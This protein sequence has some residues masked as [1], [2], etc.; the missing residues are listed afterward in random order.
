VT[1]RS[2]I[3]R[4]V[5]FGAA[6]LALSGCSV[7]FHPGS[8]A[9]V[10]GTAIS[11][12]QVND[13][14]DAACS[15]TAE[16]R[17]T[18]SRYPLVGLADLRSGIVTG[19]VQEEITQQVADKQGLTVS[20]AQVN[21]IA[22]QNV[23]SIP[24]AVPDD[25][26]E[27]LTTFFDDQARSNIL[28]ALIGKHAKDSSV[29]DAGDLTTDEIGAASKPWMKAYFEDADVS[30]DPSF[31]HWNGTTLDPG[32]GSLSQPAS[33]EKAELTDAEQCG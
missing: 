28:Q 32:T 7:D 30:V 19:M 33:T 14:T 27:A 9:D 10:N 15:Y 24:D 11:Q 26:R 2:R 17:K 4:T 31:G 18:D 20:D 22:V 29:T 23:N 25:D 6:V 21:S 16:L 12:G 5:G 3:L 13:I 1:T 8:A